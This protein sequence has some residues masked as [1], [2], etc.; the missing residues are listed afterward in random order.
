MPLPHPYA[1]IVTYE[2]SQPIE[3]YQPFFTELMHSHKWFRYMTNTWIVLRHDTLQETSDKLLPLVFN[4]DKILIMPAKGP[5]LGW[6]PQP[7]W[8]WLNA[9]VPK[10][11]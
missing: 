3:R 1:Y 10:E 11:W 2:M 7:A 8:D 5:A 9:N 4:T 6:L